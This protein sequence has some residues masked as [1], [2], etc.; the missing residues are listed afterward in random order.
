MTCADSGNLTARR[1]SP[2]VHDLPAPLATMEV[3][4]IA[5][6]SLRST[7]TVQER[8][9]L[10]ATMEGAQLAGEATQSLTLVP[11]RNVHFATNRTVSAGLRAKLRYRARPAATAARADGSCTHIGISTQS[12][13]VVDEVP[14]PVAPATAC[15][16]IWDQMTHMSR[17]EWAEACRRVDELRLVIRN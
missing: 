5:E 17:D 12:I 4:P 8:S 3:A 7:G 6:F 2:T 14:A 15:E 9:A 16:Q 1:A 10:A 13:A 11:E